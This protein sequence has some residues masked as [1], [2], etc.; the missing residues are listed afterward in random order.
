MVWSFK[1][2]EPIYTQLIDKI[3]FQI[4]SGEFSPGERLPS[5]RDFAAE[6]LVNPNTM[7][8]ALSELEKTKLISSSRSSGRFVTEDSNLI[9]EIRST[10]ANE[11]IREFINNMNSLGIKK[12]E[13]IDSIQHIMKEDI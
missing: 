10:L 12:E 5:V 2:T 13:I 1:D 7:Q 4:I 8:K 6:A 11:K 9:K 3:K